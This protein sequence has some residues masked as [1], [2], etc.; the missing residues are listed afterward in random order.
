GGFNMNAIDWENEF[1]IDCS[2]CYGYCCCA[3]CFFKIDGFPYDK[4]NQEACHYLQDDFKC[5]IHPELK[6]KGLKGCLSYDCLGAGQKVASF[7][8]DH[9]QTKAEQYQAFMKMRALHEML[10]YLK[11]AQELS[12]KCD[13]R[14][15]MVRMSDQIYP[16]TLDLDQ[17]K[18]CD[19]EDLRNQVNEYLRKTSESLRNTK[20]I[21]NKHDFMGKDFKGKRIENQDFRGALLIH[22]NMAHCI[23]VNCDF[24][25]A[26]FRDLNIQGADLSKS[27]FL[28]Q[29]QINEANGD[30]NTILPLHLKKPTHWK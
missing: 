3:L 6:S 19:I 5:K 24:I 25:G 26:D 21:V 30:Q 9:Q 7:F 23:I 22:A 13:D 11:Q 14:E 20:S 17:L 15:K 12:N 2:N 28:T 4:K 29:M 18:A 8:K 27:H 16:I 10:W 1:K